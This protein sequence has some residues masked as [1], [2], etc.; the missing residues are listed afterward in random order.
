[1]A[2]SVNEM[3]PI[4]TVPPAEGVEVADRLN[5][6]PDVNEVLAKAKVSPVV[7]P[8]L[9]VNDESPVMLVSE[10]KKAILFASDDPDEVTVP[11]NA[12]A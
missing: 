3:V 2:A 9:Y 5:K 11:V 12:H 10:V 6:V 4:L 1:M 7:V 8:E